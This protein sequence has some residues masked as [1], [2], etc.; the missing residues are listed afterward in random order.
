MKAGDVR[1]YRPVLC[2][3]K[4]LAPLLLVEVINGKRAVGISEENHKKSIRRSYFLSS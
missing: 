4:Y 3:K 1:I 2:Y